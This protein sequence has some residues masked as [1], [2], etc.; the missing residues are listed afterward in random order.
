MS[1]DTK[2]E[3]D[4]NFFVQIGEGETK[5]L[6]EVWKDPDNEQWYLEDSA[7]VGMSTIQELHDTIKEIE[8]R[9]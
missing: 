1:E 4:P 6:R 5:R 3:T 8:K 2:Q 9:D 7:G